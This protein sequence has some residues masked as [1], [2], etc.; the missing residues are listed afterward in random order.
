MYEVE[1]RTSTAIARS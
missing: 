1:E